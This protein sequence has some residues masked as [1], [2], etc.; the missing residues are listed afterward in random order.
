MV[1]QAMTLENRVGSGK[2]V[3]GKLGDYVSAAKGYISDVKDSIREDA[4]FT[5]NYLNK[6][7]AA[8]RGYV[9]SD[10]LAGTS[11]YV[12]A[13]DA[14]K[15]VG[16][17]VR[18]GVLIGTVVG[19]SILY[20]GCFGRKGGGG[21]PLDPLPADY[22]SP[23]ITLDDSNEVVKA[24]GDPWPTIG[25]AV[26]DDMDPNPQHGYDMPGVVKD[27]NGQ[28]VPSEGGYIVWAE[29]N[30]GNRT[31][32]V[33]LGARSVLEGMHVGNP[34]LKDCLEAEVMNS[35]GEMS[36]V[37]QVLEEKGYLRNQ[38]TGASIEGV[39]T[40]NNL[41]WT[42][43]NQNGIE[44]D[45]VLNEDGNLRREGT[46][47][48]LGGNSDNFTMIDIASGEGYTDGDGDGKTDYPFRNFTKVEDN[49]FNVDTLFMLTS[50]PPYNLNSVAEKAE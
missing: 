33:I 31:P 27:E 7:G 13:G 5:M 50:F 36:T 30:A 41:E 29:D 3:K 37:A 39:Y 1:T 8:V 23:V 16:K 4:S 45:Y 15:S 32:D 11:S 14:L 20:T 17:D 2:G 35:A 38:G 46:G 12:T 40:I 26:K 47:V 34:V 18:L 24:L 28:E 42:I 21:S 43:S 25:Y 6:M 19:S 22:T 48:V 44:F 10:E 49:K 9:G